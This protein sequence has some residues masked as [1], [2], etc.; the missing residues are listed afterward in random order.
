MVQPFSLVGKNILV[1]GASGGIGRAITIQC[2]TQGGTLSLT[3][4]TQEKLE[5]V[6]ALLSGEGHNVIPADLSL[7]SDLEKIAGSVP[8]LDGL[9]LNAGILKTVPVRYLKKED[10]ENMMNVNFFSSVFLLQKLLKNKK[11]KAGASVCFISSISASFVHPGNAL[12][13]ASKGAVNSFTRSTA[14]EL[15]PKK[16]RVNAVLPGMI[17]TELLEKSPIDET[18][19][20]KH[21]NNYPLG[22]FGKPE[23]VAGLVG[24]LLSDASEWMTGSLLTLDGGYSL[25]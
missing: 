22:R 11:I 2:S 17:E 19:L 7:D 3:A 1:T 13:S 8:E 5:E 20:E 18:N 16:I 25:K 21:R 4:R 6:K 12:Y 24:Y 9:V 10:A 14:L 23:D 15:A